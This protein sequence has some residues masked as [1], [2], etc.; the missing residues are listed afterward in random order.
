MCSPVP[1]NDHCNLKAGNTLIVGRDWCNI[2]QSFKE[3]QKS[4]APKILKAI[5]Q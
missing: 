2:L 4:F 5:E 3:T 1:E